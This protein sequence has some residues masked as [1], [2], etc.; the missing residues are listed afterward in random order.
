MSEKRCLVPKSSGTSGRQRIVP[1][2]CAV[3]TANDHSNPEKYKFDGFA[4]EKVVVGIK[5]PQI[6]KLAFKLTIRDRYGLGHAVFGVQI[7]DAEQGHAGLP[8]PVGVEGD[9]GVRCVFSR[10]VLENKLPSGMAALPFCQ[11]VNLVF[12]YNYCLSRKHTFVYGLLREEVVHSTRLGQVQIEMDNKC[13]SI[14][15]LLRYI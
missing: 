10:Q 13:T 6:V 1:R 9:G 4:K 5:Q 7:A 15:I 2:L 12:D 11:V 3:H 14:L 8:N